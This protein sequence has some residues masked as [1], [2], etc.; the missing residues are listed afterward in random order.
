MSR[1]TR[2][3]CALA[4]AGLVGGFLP[5]V[6]LTSAASAIEGCEHEY[7]PVPPLNISS[8]YTCDDVTQPDTTLQLDP[9][10]NAADWRTTD[11]VTFTFAA[12]APNDPDLATMTLRCSLTG[13][14]QAFAEQDCTSPLTITGLEDSKEEPYTF[15]VHAVDD[16]GLANLSGDNEVTKSPLDF[17]TPDE[18]VTK[19]YDETPAVVT[20][21]QDTTAP[22]GLIVGGPY[23]ELS[24][25]FPVLWARSTKYT[26]GSSEKPVTPTCTL[27]TRSVPCQLGTTTLS[28]LSAGTKTFSMRLKDPA[29]NVDPTLRTKK[30]TVPY[31]LLGTLSE[32]KRWKRV[33]ADG[34]FGGDYLET[35]RQ[36]AQLTKQVSFTELRLL[37]PK[38]PGLGSFRIKVGDYY[39][40]IINQASSTPKNVVVVL[41]GPKSAPMSGLLKLYTLSNKPVRFD[42]IMYR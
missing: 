31:N 38:G 18:V 11:S 15:S 37:V 35:R 17:V 26:L 34:Y 29:G 19:D 13:P 3:W 24:P 25:D 20:W 12:V 30:F 21:K 4:A 10:P 8:Q 33:S 2:T 28:N 7:N 9:A 23:D 40:R 41:R 36:G 16:G 6:A 1:H 5:L 22:R 39:F 32:R 14:S 27:N 42:A